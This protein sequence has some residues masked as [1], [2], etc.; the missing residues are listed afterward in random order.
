MQ[1]ITTGI[2]NLRLREDEHLRLYSTEGTVTRVADFARTHVGLL[3]PW[4]QAYLCE[5]ADRLEK[6][7]GS[8]LDRAYVRTEKLADGWQQME[9]LRCGSRSALLPGRSLKIKAC[10]PEQATFPEWKINGDFRLEVAEIPFGV[11]SVE[12]ALREILAYCFIDHHGLPITSTPLDVME[13]RSLGRTLGY[14]LVSRCEVN[15]RVEA[16]IDARGM[17]LHRLLRLAKTPQ[18]DKYLGTEVSLTG[19]NREDYMDSKARILVQLHSYG[20]FRGVLNS[21]LGNDL[22]QGDT[23]AGLCDFDTFQI[24]N[25]PV[26][27]ASA[28]IRHFVTRAV[29]EVIKSSLPIVDY[30]D[31]GGPPP[32][33]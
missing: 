29:L 22:V 25:P 1:T 12:G 7:E 21:N 33:P 6:I 28:E 19:M 14:G 5:G 27:G 26:A 8:G 18:R 10:R 16:C 24:V 13:F 32:P 17:T 30:L 11:L 2:G 4:E 31:L 9:A 20:G 3:A 23:F 15:G